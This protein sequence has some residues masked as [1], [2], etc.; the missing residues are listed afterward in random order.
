MPGKKA[1]TIKKANNRQQAT[2]NEV[3]LAFSRIYNDTCAGSANLDRSFFVA[4]LNTYLVARGWRPA[5]IIDIA[6]GSNLD[7]AI[8]SMHS[9]HI[10]IELLKQRHDI[11]TGQAT[12]IRVLAYNPSVVNASS[13]LVKDLSHILANKDNNNSDSC[14]NQERRLLG[15]KCKD[16]F[17]CN[18]NTFIDHMVTITMNHTNAPSA[19]GTKTLKSVLYTYCCKDHELIKVNTSKDQ[20]MMN[21]YLQE[22]DLEGVSQ[23]RASV[24]TFK[25]PA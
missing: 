15:Y 12:H 3:A 23:M 19:P 18:S 2:R 4:F 22:L 24:D 8:S 1:A 9:S 17:P 10:N 25:P 11:R 21:T 20:S 7:H 14:V 5:A 13:K 16:G 6:I